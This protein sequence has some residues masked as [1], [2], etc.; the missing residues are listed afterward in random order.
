M[1]FLPSKFI[2]LENSY[3][4]EHAIGYLYTIR[5]EFEI[6][7]DDFDVYDIDSYVNQKALKFGKTTIRNFKKRMSAHKRDTKENIYIIHIIPI[8]SEHYEKKF[9]TSF[10]NYLDKRDM[11]Y[12]F[13][14]G[15]KNKKY[16]EYYPNF[17]LDLILLVMNNFREFEKIVNQ[18]G[19]LEKFFIRFDNIKKRIKDKD[20]MDID[21]I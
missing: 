17:C 11:Y 2:N 1:N 6:C 14:N 8:T 18:N 19:N 20:Y 10:T 16:T 9:H 3:S 7:N 21:C 13:S 5:Y 12:D 4:K 15:I